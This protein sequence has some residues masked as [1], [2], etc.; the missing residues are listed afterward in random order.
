M[1]TDFYWQSRGEGGSGGESATYKVLRH[2][3]GKKP[4]RTGSG[5]QNAFWTIFA[6]HPHLRIAQSNHVTSKYPQGLWLVF[7]TVT[8]DLV[9]I[10]GP[11][12]QI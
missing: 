3:N 7:L 1:F 6:H 9:N 8:F 4:L 10:E 11:L 2:G 5:V 12:I